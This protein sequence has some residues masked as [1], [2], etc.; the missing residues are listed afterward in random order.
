MERLLKKL[1]DDIAMKRCEQILLRNAEY[2]EKE[3][4]GTFDK[5][6]LQERRIA[7]STSSFMDGFKEAI[8]IMKW[9]IAKDNK[10]KSLATFLATQYKVVNFQHVSKLDAVDGTWT[11]TWLPRL[12]PESS[13]CKIKILLKISLKREYYCI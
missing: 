13:E 4:D 6:E 8:K 12:E 9:I 2:I 1:F 11:R 5:N 7:F 10:L 3:K